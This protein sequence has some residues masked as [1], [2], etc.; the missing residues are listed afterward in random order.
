MSIR[1]SE[2]TIQYISIADSVHDFGLKLVKNFTRR[3]S[4]NTFTDGMEER[5]LYEVSNFKEDNFI[6]FEEINKEYIMNIGENAHH[7]KISFAITTNDI[8]NPKLLNFIALVVGSHDSNNHFLTADHN[9]IPKKTMCSINE[10][11]IPLIQYAMTMSTIYDR[12]FEEQTD[13]CVKSNNTTAK[14]T[15]ADGNLFG[16]ESIST[17]DNNVLLKFPPYHRDIHEETSIYKNV[18]LES[19][20]SGA[21]RFLT[22]FKRI[23][24]HFT[25]KRL[26]K[27]QKTG[28]GKRGRDEDED[29]I[30]IPIIEL[31]QHLENTYKID[32]KKIYNI[33]K[34]EN[35]TEDH[36]ESIV[37]SAAN[38][39]TMTNILL[40]LKR[41]GDQLQVKTAKNLQSVFI[42]NDRLAIAYAF[43]IDV[44]SIKTAT[45]LGSGKK[46]CFYNFDKTKIQDVFDNVDYYKRAH[47]KQI[48]NLSRYR[49]FLSNFKERFNQKYINET[50]RN[51]V[52]SKLDRFENKLKYLVKNLNIL[53]IGQSNTRRLQLDVT[54]SYEYMTT[55]LFM[56]ATYVNKIIHICL[57]DYQNIEYIENLIQ[58][59]E[60]QFNNIIR[61]ANGDNTYLQEL[62]TIT[63]NVSNHF[64]YKNSLF[65]NTANF[66]NTNLIS[67]KYLD[68]I[69]KVLQAFQEHDVH[70]YDSVEAFVSAVNEGDENIIFNEI[71]N[72]LINIYVNE[73]I[74]TS[75]IELNLLINILT[76][77]NNMQISNNFHKSAIYLVNT[78]VRPTQEL[79][80]VIKFIKS[81]DIQ[82][83]HRSILKLLSKLNDSG[84]PGLI[85]NFNIDS[86]TMSTTGGR[87]PAHMSIN[88]IFFKNKD[89]SLSQNKSSFSKN[90]RSLSKYVFSKPKMQTHRDL[91][92]EALHHITVFSNPKTEEFDNFCKTV[93]LFIS[94]HY[95]DEYGYLI[96][97]KELRTISSMK[98][99]TSPSS[100]K[101]SGGKINKTKNIKANKSSVRNKKN[102]QDKGFMTY[103]TNIVSHVFGI[104]DN[105]KK[106]K[107]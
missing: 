90:K 17:G 72:E 27:K 36:E 35:P 48:E 49:E 6:D 41:A 30:I 13:N 22:L 8:N 105:D 96:S 24:E 94:N 89:M 78:S 21:G 85:H 79:N 77:W 98:S 52:K 76:R 101:M 57:L 37:R 87:E 70:S 29:S 15:K 58:N 7:G 74:T 5:V 43:Q 71:I 3:N 65:V 1:S 31:L 26:A 56:L 102:T 99:S 25:N 28:G 16:L 34:D 82:Q 106:K 38:H 103:F 95:F 54:V 51:N 44:P 63:N 20:S 100:L 69:F 61:S 62:N 2:E 64:T 33:N 40:D 39:D 12:G 80:V 68:Y 86:R 47:G 45:Y 32:Y 73:P 83:Q 46:I 59:F 19:Q 92:K 88:D 97:D 42:S 67:V 60:T 75:N 23:I 107:R 9:N 14:I 53:P 93:I 11:T 84:I 91:L 66:D 104:T 81:N 18:F 4:N 50:D 55:Y 10:G